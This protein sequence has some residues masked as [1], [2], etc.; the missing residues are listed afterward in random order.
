MSARSGDVQPLGVD[1]ESCGSRAGKPCTRPTGAGRA[2]MAGYH[3][4]REARAQ[5]VTG[6]SQPVADEVDRH[7]LRMEDFPPMP[8]TSHVANVL[9][10]ELGEPVQDVENNRTTF[11]FT[12]W[13]NAMRGGDDAS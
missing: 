8:A 4:V 10:M 13:S 5:W 12:I 7:R 2:F 11:P 9:T 1:C 6:L 3:M